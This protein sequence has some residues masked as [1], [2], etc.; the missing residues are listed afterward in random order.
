MMFVSAL[1]GRDDG[2]CTVVSAL[3]LWVTQ[4]TLQAELGADPC[5]HPLMS[6]GRHHPPVR[7]RLICVWESVNGMRK[8]YLPALV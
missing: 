7:A 1:C 5:P 2:E 4:G 3:T 8:P 6:C